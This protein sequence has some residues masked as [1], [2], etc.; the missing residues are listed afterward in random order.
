MTSLWF[1]LECVLACVLWSQIAGLSCGEFGNLPLPPIPSQRTKV[2]GHILEYFIDI[3]EIESPK[4]LW[5]RD[6]FVNQPLDFHN[7]ME[8]IQ[9]F[10]DPLWGPSF[11]GS[12]SEISHEAL[13]NMAELEI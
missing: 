13:S 2:K 10:P 4:N 3:W 7:S 8:S 12:Q 5:Y 11:P 9:V 6:P 1:A